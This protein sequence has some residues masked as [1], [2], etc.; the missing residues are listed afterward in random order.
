MVPF[1]S[2]NHYQQRDYKILPQFCID[3]ATAEKWWSR[4]PALMDMPVNSV[5]GIP[6]SGCRVTPSAVD[7]TIEV[8]GYALPGGRDGPVR[9]VEV[10]GDAG[11]TWTAAEI[12]EPPE[13]MG[14]LASRWAWS[15]WRARVKVEKGVKRCVWSRATDG[16]DTQPRFP[17]WNWRGLAYNG[18]GEAVDLLVE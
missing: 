9:R 18:Y 13:E 8:K 15:L 5:V 2:R 3:D 4:T 12:L 10:S 17:E 16:R 7:S 6:Q 14:R 11:R 1:E